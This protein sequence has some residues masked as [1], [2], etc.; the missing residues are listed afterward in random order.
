V[1]GNER[2][3]EKEQREGGTHGGVIPF[4]DLLWI[5]ERRRR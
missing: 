5:S 1:H 4:E 2:E 3:K